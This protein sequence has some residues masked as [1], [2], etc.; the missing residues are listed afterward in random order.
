MPR[1]LSP[2]IFLA[3]FLEAQVLILATSPNFNNYSLFYVL[4]IVYIKFFL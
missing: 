1:A 3:G 2:R 4:G